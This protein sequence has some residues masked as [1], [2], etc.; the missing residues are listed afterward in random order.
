MGI[1]PIPTKNRT[2]KPTTTM[3]EIQQSMR[4]RNRTLWDRTHPTET[5]IQVPR[6][7]RTHNATKETQQTFTTSRTSATENQ[8]TSYA[9]LGSAHA[10]E[11]T[12]KKKAQ[13]SRN[14]GNGSTHRNAP[15]RHHPLR[16]D[17][18]NGKN[19][20]Q[21]HPPRKPGAHHLKPTQIPNHRNYRREISR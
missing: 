13:R 10:C 18:Q 7:P 16:N 21:T 12:P 15:G 3:R 19:N 5:Q 2:N 17:L 14:T 11:S 20:L 1:Q 4:P 6:K 8:R 9:N